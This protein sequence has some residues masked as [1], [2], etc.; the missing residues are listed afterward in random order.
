VLLLKTCFSACGNSAIIVPQQLIKTTV[1]GINSS[2]CLI[3][4]TGLSATC[5]RPQQTLTEGRFIITFGLQTTRMENTPQPIFSHAEPVLAVEDVEATIDY[6][7]T[8]LGFPGKWT[9]GEP[10]TMGSVSWQKIF[11]Q[12]IK[13]PA[14]AASSKGNNIW[15]RL[16][17]IEQLYAI[18]QK[19]KADIVDPLE[20]KPYGLAQ[21]TVREM[22][23][24]YLHFAG[25]LEPREKSEQ[26]MPPGI[27][28]IDRPPTAAE[29]AAFS[30][31][32]VTGDDIMV[33][34][35]L[36]AAVFGVI[37]RQAST[38]MLIG[39]ALLTGDNASYYYV[40]DVMLHPQWQ[41]KRLGTAMMQRIDEWLQ[42]N[43]AQG[44]MVSL[45]ARE[46]LE[47]FYQQF[48]FSQSFAMI[49]FVERDEER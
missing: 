1:T 47:P 38:G 3:V 12:F 2:Y 34:K 9:W 19:N 4:K 29:Y 22:N 28:I 40:K 23:G 48:G 21:Y 45:I 49:K 32:P 37:A 17:R 11:I 42:K 27:E 46:T 25:N 44:A 6:W 24:Y 10:P 35:R 8:V 30:G 33:Q 5:K 16:R 43:G 7:Q 39:F 41:G 14:L 13:N 20:L 36:A 26:T 15:I 31:I 18:H